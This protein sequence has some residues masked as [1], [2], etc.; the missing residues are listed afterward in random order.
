MGA[1]GLVRHCWRYLIGSGVG[2]ALKGKLNHIIK[3]L[4]Y[5]GNGNS[6]ELKKNKKMAKIIR[7]LFNYLKNF[8]KF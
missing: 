2:D 5:N 8:Y 7:L 4:L 3:F 6:I 1:S